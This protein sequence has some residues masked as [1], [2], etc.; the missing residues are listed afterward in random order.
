MKENFFEK[1]RIREPGKPRKP[2]MSGIRGQTGETSIFVRDA[3]P[4]EPVIQKASRAGHFHLLKEIQEENKAKEGDWKNN[5]EKVKNGDRVKKGQKIGYIESS[6]IKHEVRVVCALKDGIITGL[7]EDSRQGT[8]VE[9][10]EALFTITPTLE[11]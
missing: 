5:A 9:F 4:K 6:E 3:F 2:S 11:K 7:P 1:K 8:A 10:N